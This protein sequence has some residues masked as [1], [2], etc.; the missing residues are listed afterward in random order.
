MDI[1]RAFLYILPLSE[2]RTV[3]KFIL[4]SDPKLN[5]IP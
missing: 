1:N 3:L 5:S 2:N 4:N